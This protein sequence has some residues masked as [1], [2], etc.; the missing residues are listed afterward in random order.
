[1]T[2]WESNPDTASSTL[3]ANWI[4]VPEPSP[5]LGLFLYR[6]TVPYGWGRI[7]IKDAEAKVPLKPARCA[8]FTP[9]AFGASNL[10][11]LAD[12]EGERFCNS[13]GFIVKFLYL[14][15]NLCV[16]ATLIPGDFEIFDKL[17]TC[18]DNSLHF[19]NDSTSQNNSVFDSFKQK[20]L[21][22]VEF[23]TWQSPIFQTE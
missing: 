22:G 2:G 16:S 23:K 15:W 19:Q 14:S 18:G 10:E 7:C 13:I 3:Q 4:L 17:D 6:R 1:M 8:F 20:W 21:R 11:V 5:A 12:Y 9:S